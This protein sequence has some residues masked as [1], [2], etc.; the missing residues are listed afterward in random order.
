MF[1]KVSVESVKVLMGQDLG[2]SDFSNY[3]IVGKENSMY[4]DVSEIKIRQDSHFCIVTLKHY[5]Q[6][7]SYVAP[8]CLPEINNQHYEEVQGRPACKPC[9]RMIIVL[10]LA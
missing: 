7:N 1:P 8:L 5:V 4:V 2:T 9:L 3:D 6:F 10:K